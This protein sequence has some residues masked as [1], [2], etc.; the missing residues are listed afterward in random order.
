MSL[1]SVLSRLEL[2]QAPKF[3]L[4]V[5]DHVDFA[6]A[7][8]TF[9]SN[10]GH[11]V[12][13]ILGVEKVDGDVLVGIP[14]E[15]AELVKVDLTLIQV[16]FLDHYFALSQASGQKWDGSSLTLAL[17]RYPSIK[18]MGMSSVSR[19]NNSMIRNGA[20]FGMVKMELGLLLQF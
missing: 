5:E 4:I 7:I 14:L 1:D 18:I 17:K 9:L 20:D 2:D 11:T 10:M 16:A 19:A 15:G 6:K 12:V 8:H 3:I 13:T